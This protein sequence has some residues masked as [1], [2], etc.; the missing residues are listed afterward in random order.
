M[1]AADPGWC[2]EAWNGCRRWLRRDLTHSLG[3]PEVGLE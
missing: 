2:T 3:L 1:V